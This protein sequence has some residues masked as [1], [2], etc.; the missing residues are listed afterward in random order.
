[1]ARRFTNVAKLATYASKGGGFG[2]ILN[3]PAV[4]VVYALKKYFDHSFKSPIR[5]G[6]IAPPSF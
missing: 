1:M 2:G 5:K 6:G 4:V 3:G